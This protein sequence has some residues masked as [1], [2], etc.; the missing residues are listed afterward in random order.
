MRYLK[1]LFEDTQVVIS[2]GFR[3]RTLINQVFL[4]SYII[5]KLRTLPSKKRMFKWKRNIST[6]SNWKRVAQMNNRKAAP[7]SMRTPDMKVH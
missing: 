7:R 4:F 6:M 1:I 5:G 3:Y 2:P